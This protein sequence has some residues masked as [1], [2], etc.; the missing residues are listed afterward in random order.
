M[1]IV[2]AALALLGLFISFY[3]MLYRMKVVRLYCPEGGFVNC[4]R[5]LDTNPKLLGIQTA[6][7][8]AA[9]FLIELPL[10]YYAIPPLIVAIYNMLGLLLVAWLVSIQIRLRAICVYCVASHC[11]IIVLFLLSLHAVF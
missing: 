6:A 1:D 9:F 4:K 8:G 11:V 2:Y 5:V 7:L 3:I 10:S